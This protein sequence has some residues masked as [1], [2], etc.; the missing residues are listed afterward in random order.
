MHDD[1]RIRDK[2]S[3][4]TALQDEAVRIVAAASAQGRSLT[5]AEDSHVLALMGLSVVITSSGDQISNLPS[6]LA[7]Y[8]T[9]RYEEAGRDQDPPCN[10]VTV[11][12]LNYLFSIATEF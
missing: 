6:D 2:E 7:K 4:R 8:V 10:N 1:P 12:W 5:A 11:V 9:E 3:E